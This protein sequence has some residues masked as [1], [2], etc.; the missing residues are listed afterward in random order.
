ME[1][2]L[3]DCLGAVRIPFIERYVH[4]TNDSIRCVDRRSLDVPAILTM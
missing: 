2:S 1:Q 3:W 4:L